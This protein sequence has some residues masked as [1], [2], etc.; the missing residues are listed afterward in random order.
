M[1]LRSSLGSLKK[2]NGSCRFM[3]SGAGG[4]FSFRYGF[5]K[6]FTRL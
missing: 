4:S 5:G 2:G 6:A 1:R 3:E